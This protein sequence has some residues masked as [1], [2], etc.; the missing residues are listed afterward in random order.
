[1]WLIFHSD[2][3]SKSV[4]QCCLGFLPSATNTPS[5]HRPNQ[6]SS[7]DDLVHA[8]RRRENSGRLSFANRSERCRRTPRSAASRYPKSAGPYSTRCGD[9]SVSLAAQ[10]N[11]PRFLQ[12]GCVH[13]QVPFGGG[14]GACSHSS[15]QKELCGWA[16]HVQAWCPQFF[17]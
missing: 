4:Y 14:A 1:M 5:R 13:G 17:G 16:W 6:C 10:Q 12:P 3:R 8:S 11:Y 2:W 9:A 7:L 15:L